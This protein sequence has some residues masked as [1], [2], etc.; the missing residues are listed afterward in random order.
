MGSRTTTRVIAAAACTFAAA[1]AA[2]LAAAGPPEPESGHAQAREGLRPLERLAAALPAGR[3]A[4]RAPAHSADAVPL[5]SVG[6]A[7]AGRHP[8][9]HRFVFPVAGKV[10]YGEEGARFGTNRG[11]REHEGQDMFA[12]AGTPLRAVQ[13]GVVV[14]TGDDG[15]RGNYIAIFSRRARRTYVYLH[16]RDPARQRPGRRVRAGDSRRARGLQRLL[17]G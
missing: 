11:G 16:M 7:I 5:R 13:D 12:P 6:A 10:G 8:V 1:S 17:L 15:G 2:G 9:R 4:L 14:E 3:R